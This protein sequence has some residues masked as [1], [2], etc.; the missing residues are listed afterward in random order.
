M[1]K[2]Y[3][4]CI[5][6]RGTR[7]F[8]FSWATL[9]GA[10]VAAKGVP[11]IM[12]TIEVVIA[13]STIV[14]SIYI[15]NDVMDLPIDKINRVD[16]P[17]AQ[18]QISAKNA[19][20]F[21]FILA[22]IGITISFFIGL[23]TFLICLALLTLGFAYSIPPI[24]LKKRFMF[25][26]TTTAIGASLASIAGGAALGNISWSV[27][28]AGFMF[29]VYAFAM[30]PILDLGDIKGDFVGERKTLPIIFG[31]QNTVKTAIIFM[32]FMSA[33]SIIGFFKLGFNVALPI[34]VS[35]SCLLCAWSLYPLLQR[36]HDSKYVNIQVKKWAFM[37][38]IIQ[39]AMIMGSLQ[40]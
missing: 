6:Y 24:Q 2:P 18:R 38:F 5:K 1:L 37:L 17:I 30:A 32:F 40:V 28:F 23:S 12:I 34:L 14:S 3:A 9:I 11:P 15:F 16:R 20:T 10:L 22:I 4:L 26:Q 33:S 36:W 39:L 25:K 7:I 31:P 35:L 19:E 8:S 13:I 29:F 21:A 27:L